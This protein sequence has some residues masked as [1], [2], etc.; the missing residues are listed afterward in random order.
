LFP[1][2][3]TPPK[4]AVYNCF[5]SQLPGI[6]K[7]AFT[8]IESLQPYDSGPGHHNVMAIIANFLM[9]INTDT[10]TQS[11]PESPFVKISIPPEGFTPHP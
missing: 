10:L 3:I 6:S 11:C 8:L 2:W 7:T 4:N 5:S 9:S 1:L